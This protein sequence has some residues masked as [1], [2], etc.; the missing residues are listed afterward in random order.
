MAVSKHFSCSLVGWSLNDQIRAH[1]TRSMVTTV[2]R[3]H[4]FFSDLQSIQVE[5]ITGNHPACSPGS[6]LRKQSKLEIAALLNLF[7]VE[8]K[9]PLHLATYIFSVAA[10]YPGRS[11]LLFC[12]CSWT[13]PK[14]FMKLKAEKLQICSS[15]IPQLHVLVCKFITGNWLL[16]N[17]SFWTIGYISPTRCVAHSLL[18]S[19]PGLGWLQGWCSLWGGREKQWI[20]LHAIS[21]QQP[22][23]LI[24]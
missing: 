21:H 2:T 12:C 18:L 3:L 6:R 9:G 5:F 14:I 8:N 13:M 17:S 11:R 7:L 15:Y 16:T 19:L 4:L 20:E 23:W 1:S 22:L 10:F 24:K